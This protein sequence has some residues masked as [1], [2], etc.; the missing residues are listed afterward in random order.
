MS[1]ATHEL[2]VR[3]LPPAERHPLIFEKF[4]AL[5]PGESFVLVNDHE[6]RPL[7]YQFRAERSGTFL[8]LPSLEG[9]KEW[10]IE[11]LKCRPKEEETEVTAY[12]GRD[13]DEIDAILGFLRHDISAAVRDPKRPTLG[14]VRLFDEF[15]QRL[16]RH[17]RWEEELLFPA[18]EAK[19]PDLVHGPGRV[20]RLEHEEIRRYK[21]IAA[22]HLHD[23]KLNTDGVRRA[24]EALQSMLEILV[25]HNHKEEAVY[26]PMSDQVHT[27][28]ESAELLARVRGLK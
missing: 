14:I 9:P 18:V 4:D 3:S 26:Y 12:F 6:P 20:M 7:Y 2:D 24:A 23:P 13:H 17:I 27:A 15:N 22:K 25:G 10:R 19:L 1:Q 11:I 8:W 16:E 5:A 28:A 21:A